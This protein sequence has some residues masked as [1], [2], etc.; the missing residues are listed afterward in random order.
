MANTVRLVFDAL[1][2]PTRRAVLERLCHGPRPVGQI[3]RGLPVTRPAVS[4]HLKVL[5]D[6]GLV[7]DRSEGTRRIY[8]INPEG[9]GALRA[10]MDQFWEGA[11][12]ASV[13]DAER[14]HHGLI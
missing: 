2:D 8:S 5:K 9:L 6:A 4:Q 11:L 14:S 13:A 12:A 1:S 10:W 3:A 7:S